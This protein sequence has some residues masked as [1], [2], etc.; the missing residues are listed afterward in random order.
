MQRQ[1][2]QARLHSVKFI[3]RAGILVNEEAEFVDMEILV[4]SMIVIVGQHGEP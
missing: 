3:A 1:L 2:S 4:L